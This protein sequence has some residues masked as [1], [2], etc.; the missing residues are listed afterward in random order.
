MAERKSGDGCKGCKWYTR[1]YG[2]GTCYYCLKTGKSRG[3]PAGEGCIRY[4]KE[5]KK[6]RYKKYLAEFA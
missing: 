4:E 6:T 3:C 2:E 1:G 5:D